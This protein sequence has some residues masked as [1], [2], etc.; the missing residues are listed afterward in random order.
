MFPHGFWTSPIWKEAARAGLRQI[1]KMVG[2]GNL[3]GASQLA[4]IPGVLK[5]SSAGSQIQHLGRGGEGLATMV[6]HPDHGVAVRKLYDPRGISGQD[7]IAR[8]EQAGRALGDNPNFAKF[9]GSSQT[10]QGGQMHFNEYISPGQAP[11]GQAG[12]QSVRHTQVQAQ[13]GLTNA[14][15]AGGKDIRK[16]N[17]IYDANAGQHRV[18]DYIPAQQGEF[19]RMPKSMENRLA[20]SPDSKSPFNPAYS[21]QTS[22][23]TGGMLGRLLGGRSQSGGIRESAGSLGSSTTQPVPAMGQTLAARPG[24]ARGTPAQPTKPM[25]SPPSI[26]T[27][28]TF[29]SQA[30]TTPLTPTSNS[31]LTSVLKPQTPPV[32][33]PVSPATAVVKKPRPQ[34]IS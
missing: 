22:S 16:G 11:T 6:A 17:M 25:R 24:M 5:P 7:M 27:A 14:G 3:A 1:S 30:P 31:S 33:A 18:I 20:V 13:K 29:P 23:S 8:K 32:T 9:L 19:Q 26:A 2:Q 34:S 4:K 12:A 21:P 28:K 15:F 10:P